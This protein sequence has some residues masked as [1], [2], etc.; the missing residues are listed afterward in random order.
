M[1]YNPS[2]D[3]TGN[4]QYIYIYMYVYMFAG[5]YMYVYMYLGVVGSDVAELLGVVEAV[6]ASLSFIRIGKIIFDNESK[7]QAAV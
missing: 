1:G 2:D 5:I 6:T 4:S 3:D 7:V